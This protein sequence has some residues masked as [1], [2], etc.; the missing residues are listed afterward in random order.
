MS[1]STNATVNF[2]D[3]RVEV[4]ATDANIADNGFSDAG[5]ATTWTNGLDVRQSSFILNATMASNPDSGSAILLFA[6]LM[7]IEG[8]TD[9]N[10]PSD[11]Y[12]DLYLGFFRM[13][14][15]DTAQDIVLT[16]ADDELPAIEADQDIDFYLS[17]P[18]GVQLD[19]GATVDIIDRAPG[20]L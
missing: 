17:N 8:T 1:I 3:T 11:D 18:T 7:D 5:D 13:D 20:P 14:E 15:G 2:F 12:P 19:S 9:A 10:E 4:I 6:R 16:L